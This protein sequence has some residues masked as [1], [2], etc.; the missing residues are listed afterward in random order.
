MATP[1]SHVGQRL[2]VRS[3]PGLKSVEVVLANE[4]LGPW[5]WGGKPVM[6]AEG[7][8]TFG[9]KIKSSKAAT[10]HMVGAKA[11]QSVVISPLL[12][13]TAA[14]IMGHTQEGTAI[15]GDRTCTR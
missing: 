12:L 8:D 4:A 10:L 9:L 15:N 6:S 7:E 5:G 2:K 14:V 1:Y 3:R 11:S 13:S